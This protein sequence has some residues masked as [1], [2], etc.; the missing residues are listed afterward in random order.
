MGVAALV[1][2]M[3]QQVGARGAFRLLADV[4]ETLSAFDILH[5]AGFAIYARQRIW[6]LTGDPEG[7]V[8][9]RPWRSCSERDVIGVRTLY[10]NLVPGLVQ[11]VEPAPGGRL[12]GFVYYEGDELLGYMELKYGS[13]GIWAQPFIHPDAEN[14]TACLI[15]L[16]R[17]LPFRQSR[18]MYICVRSYQSWLE[19]AMEELGAQPGPRQAVLVKHLALAR[20]VRTVFCSAGY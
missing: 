15:E 14:V 12:R 19:M 7:E 13:Q 11:Q 18:P 17:R 16:L 2:F 6:Q 8:S 1:D 9:P 5:R 3:T 20:R 10:A 4:D